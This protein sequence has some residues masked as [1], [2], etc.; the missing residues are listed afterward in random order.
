MDAS[1]SRGSCSERAPPQLGCHAAGSSHFCEW[2][3]RDDHLPSAP[4]GL[5]LSRGLVAPGEAADAWRMPERRPP[6]PQPMPLDDL[7]EPP[8]GKT[9][10]PLSLY[11]TLL[12]R[13][14]TLNDRERTDLVELVSLF[15]DVGPEDRVLL[16]RL[17]RRLAR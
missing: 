15:A 13:F 14:D 9:N 6:V 17:G 3:R 2:F 4:A 11:Q 10:Q 7:L 12:S 8:T 16:L 5:P 1:L